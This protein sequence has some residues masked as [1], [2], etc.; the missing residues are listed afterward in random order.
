MRDVGYVGNTE[1]ALDMGRN[2]RA[3]GWKKYPDWKL[4]WDSSRWA[5]KD[6]AIR[7]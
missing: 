1:G 7:D 4:Y 2:L 6:T 3:L 5:R